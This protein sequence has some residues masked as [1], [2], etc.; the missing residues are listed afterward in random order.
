MEMNASA[1]ASQNTYSDTLSMWIIVY[2]IKGSL[3][4]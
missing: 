3:D 4:V 2:I 1:S